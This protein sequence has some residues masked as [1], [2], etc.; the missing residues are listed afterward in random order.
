[1][2]RKSKVLIVLFVLKESLIYLMG[3]G[4][5]ITYGYISVIELSSVEYKAYS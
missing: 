5:V 3:A 2:F 4:C 1:M